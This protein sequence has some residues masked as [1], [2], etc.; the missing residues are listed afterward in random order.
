MR[1]EYSPAEDWLAW[2]FA[3]II[4]LEGLAINL[5]LMGAV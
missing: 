3:G 1:D 5:I 4:F 2:L